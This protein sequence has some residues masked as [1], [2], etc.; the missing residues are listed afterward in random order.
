LLE[1]G[2]ILNRDI[3]E[4]NIIITDHTVEEDSK[5]R[6]IDLDL[7]KELDSRPSG[8]SH[9]TGTTQFVAIEVLQ[10]KGHTYRHD[11]ESFFHV[12][13]LMCIPL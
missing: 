7:A 1:N 9:W 6:L 2:K 4:N 10:S 12:F 5:G 8:A 13:I 11:L 3:S